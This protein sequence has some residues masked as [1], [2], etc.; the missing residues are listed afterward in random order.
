MTA[1]LIEEDFFDERMP[2]SEIKLRILRDYL[3]SY[4]RIRSKTQSDVYFVDGFAGTGFYKDA[5]EG[6]PVLISNLARSLLLKGSPC[7]I[8]GI[9]IEES[10][11]R[12]EELKGALSGFD[13]SVALLLRGSFEEHLGEVLRSVGNAPTVFFLDPFGVKDTPFETIKLLMNRRDTEL[14]LN[15]STPSVTRLA[16]FDRSSSAQAS[17]KRKLLSRVIGDDSSDPIWIRK[18]EE[19]NRDSSIWLEWVLEFYKD[20][21]LHN[22]KFQFALDYPIREEFGGRPKYHLIFASRHPKAISVMNDLLC[23]EEDLLFS[24]VAGGGLQTSFLPRFRESQRETESRMLLDEVYE[25]GLAHQ[26]ISL[27]K[28]VQHFAL[29][30]FAQFKTKHYRQVIRQLESQGRASTPHGKSDIAPSTFLSI[31]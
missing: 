8:H 14:L 11:S 19:S 9:Y 2:W 18:W 10:K 3:A 4:Q 7:R 31:G 16:G 29:K 23:E 30:K 24:K 15:F 28:I 26:G 6:S 5:H 20:Q 1:H 22:S 27:E 12:F 21:L 17:E 13:E 25:F